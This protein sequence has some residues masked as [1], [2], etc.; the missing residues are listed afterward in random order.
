MLNRY[1]GAA[2]PCILDNGGT[3]VQFVGDALL[4]LFNAPARLEDH[5]RRAVRAALEMQRVVEEIAAGEPGWPRLR[6]GANTG[7]ALVG[8]IGSELLR[9]F[10]AMGDA[11]NV[12]SR[13]QTLAEPGQVIIGERTFL[14]VRDDVVADPLGEL[15][16]RGRLRPV[17]AYVVR[18]PV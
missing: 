7:P 14:A 2:V 17:R 9:G 5:A 15:E 13:L 8:N 16:V 3:I 12:A 11:V 1:H 6:V 4:A 18:E 10:N